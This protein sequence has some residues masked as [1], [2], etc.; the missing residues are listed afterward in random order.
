MLTNDIKTALKSYTA[1]MENKVTFVLQTGEHAKR[2]ELKS[3]LSDIAGV[4]ENLALEERDGGTRL[5]VTE[6]FV[7]VVDEKAARNQHEG[8]TLL[9]TAGLKAHVEAA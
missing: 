6:H 8:W 3:F 9:F 7:G 2:A 5:A 1:N 4:S